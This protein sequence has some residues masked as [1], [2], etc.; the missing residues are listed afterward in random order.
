M[1]DLNKSR[2]FES[3][4]K[5][6]L[7]TLSNIPEGAAMVGTL[8]GGISKAKLSAG[9]NTEQFIGVSTGRPDRPTVAPKVDLLTVP[10]G[11][12]YTVT[13]S[14]PMNGND[15]LVT[16]IAANG[17]RTVLAAGA[18]SNANEYSISSGVITVNSSKASGKLEVI[19]NYNISL[20][21]ANAVYNFSVYGADL[22][23]EHGTIGLIT[24]GLIFTDMYDITSDW[25]SASRQVPVRIGPSGKFTL[26]SNS[27]ANQEITAIVIQVPGAGS[28]LLGLH[29][30]PG[31]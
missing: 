7:S 29:I 17:T 4:V 5:E 18:A 1:L 10:S 2:V 9:V 6:V 30:N 21:E 14:R 8:E 23:I 24:S 27:N 13:L 26:T 19:Y 20:A 12:P 28:P 22:Q 11:S 3:H 16:H 15:I 31:Y 25:S